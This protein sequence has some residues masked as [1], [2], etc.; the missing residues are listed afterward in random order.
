MPLPDR[1]MGMCA[2]VINHDGAG[3]FVRYKRPE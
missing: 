1:R 3:D 2:K